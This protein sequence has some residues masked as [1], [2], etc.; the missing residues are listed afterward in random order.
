MFWSWSPCCMVI[1]CNPHLS[2]HQTRISH[3]RSDLKGDLYHKLSPI[4]SHSHMLLFTSNAP[5]DPHDLSQHLID[6]VT[7]QYY[8]LYCG[9]LTND[10]PLM[11]DNLLI[12]GQCPRNLGRETSLFL[13]LRTF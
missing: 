6:I 5:C 12:R 11:L 4:Q 7:S 3:R 10:I 1:L 8:Y 13:D 9:L 2:L